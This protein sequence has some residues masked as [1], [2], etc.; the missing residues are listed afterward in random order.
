VLNK[1]VL[2]WRLK[3][4]VDDR[5]SFSSVGCQFHARG[6]ATEN[7]RSPIR[8]FVRGRKRSPFLKAR[9][10]ERMGMLADR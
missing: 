5:M 8:P 4:V 2:K 6:A 3:V 9:S 1:K 7:A 10:D